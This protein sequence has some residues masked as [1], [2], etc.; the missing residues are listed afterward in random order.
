MRSVVRS[1]HPNELDKLHLVTTDLPF[2]RI[3]HHWEL[4]RQHRAINADENEWRANILPT[5]NSI[6]IEA[7]LVSLAPKM[8]DIFIYVRS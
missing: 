1:F 6:G 5:S 3:P 7:Q 8:D 4:F 2:D